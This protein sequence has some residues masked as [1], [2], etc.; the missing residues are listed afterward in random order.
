MCQR[1]TGFYAGAV[2]ALA[3]ILWFRPQPDARYRWIH[4]I[5]VLSMA[6]FGFQLVSH[7]AVVRTLSGAWFGFGIVG[8]LWL[9][10][11]QELSNEERR[12][13]SWK[14]LH[15]CLGALCLILLPV[16]A[17]HG[18]AMA[19]EILPWLSVIGFAVLGGLLLLNLVLFLL[20]IFGPAIRSIV[21][22]IS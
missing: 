2:I 21:R 14:R 4:T 12:S 11:E 3:L 18:G 9:F 1:C 16:F 22:Q 5:L 13:N 7:G 6:P 15:L 10:P 20:W 8:L 17:S 19:A